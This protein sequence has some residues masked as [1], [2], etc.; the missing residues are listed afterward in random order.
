MQYLN[1]RIVSQKDNYATVTK[2]STYDLR[3]LGPEFFL[4]VYIYGAVPLTDVLLLVQN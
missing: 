3:F 2:H 1:V 4:L